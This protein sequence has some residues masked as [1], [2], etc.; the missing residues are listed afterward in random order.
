[1]LFIR[2]LLVFVVLGMEL[3]EAASPTHGSKLD[4]RGYEVL[5]EASSELNLSR[6][7]L[8]VG[9]C[10]ANTPCVNGAC[11]GSDNLCGYSPKQCGTG[12]R[13][14][15]DAK[16]ECGPYAPSS[17]QACPL[18]VCC[19][20]FGFCGSTSE[21]C[22]W[23]NKE[24][25]NYPSCNTKYGGCGDV[26]RPSCGGGSSVSKRTI[27]YYE[28]WANSRKNG[29]V[30]PEDLN[31][32]GF[33]H[34]NF[35]FSFFDASS[36][37][38][39][40]MDA[41]AASLYS[42]F[43][44]LKEKKNG[45]QAWISV[46]GWSFTDPGP[47]QKAFSN[48]VSSQSNR[49]KFI[50][51]LRQFMDTYGFDGVDLDWEYPGADDRGGVSAD[52]ANYVALTKEMRASFGTKYGISMTLPT[53]YWYLQ[54]FDLPGIQSSLDWFNLM[55]YDL[56]GTWDKA[57]KFVGPYLAPHTNNTEI[58]LGLDLLWRA[59]VNAEKVV[60]GLGLYGRSFTLADPSCNVPNGVCQFADAAKP[61]P[62]SDAAGI[63]IDTEINDII[64]K[65]NLKPTWDKEA[66]VKWITW[67]SNQWV[68]YDDSDTFQQKRDFANKRCLGGLMVWA[69]DQVDQAASNG[70]GLDGDVTSDQQDDAQ[71]LSDD[72]AA[73]MTCKATDCG[74]SC[75][76]G[77]N[78]VTETN[79][80]PG[81]LSTKDRC[82]KGQYRSICCSSGTTLGTCQWRGFRGHGLSCIGGCADG[83]TEVATNTNSHEG[84]NDLT[85]NGGQQS[86]CCKGFKPAV[87]KSELEKFAKDAAKAAAEAA[88]EQA[89]LDIA[90]KAFCRVAVPAL[91][92]P[93]ELLED[94]IP[95]VGEIL[96]IA[97]IAATPALIQL[98][99]KGIEK[100]GKAEFKVF[101][102][103]H[104]LSFDKP[105][106]KPSE[107]RPPTSSHD[108]PKTKTDDS[109]PNNRKRNDCDRPERGDVTTYD[110]GT[111]TLYTTLT[112]VCDGERWPQA[113][114]HYSSAIRNHVGAGFN[115]VTCSENAR[116]REF[117][118][119]GP[120]TN[121]WAVEKNNEWKKWMARIPTGFL[122]GQ[123][124][125]RDEWPPAHFWQ[126]DVG[127][128][129]RYNHR[130]D[131]AG[132]GSSL[133]SQF[134]PEHAAYRCVPGSGNVEN[135]RRGR[136]TTHCKKELT[137][138]GKSA[139][140][141]VAL[142][143]K[144]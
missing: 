117:M 2:S 116:P 75:P 118:G 103:K 37:E 92:A 36:F 72:Q 81:Q 80:Q 113:C 127:Q 32:D 61:G 53:S 71:S 39:T 33:T 136:P 105:T 108:S 13:Y 132:A 68:S 60:L 16:A 112:R 134:C 140:L 63:L 18:A 24:D 100:E 137:I 135:P 93:L 5:S 40:S 95:I 47:T 125:Q 9:T 94:L 8:P 35:A 31:L 101:G 106:K 26:K 111:T 49:A 3:C 77:S 25:S 57:S 67:D 10:D 70:L 86:Y 87:S 73:K 139:T 124:C 1:M 30:T 89:A 128:I 102:K 85:C 142:K 45:L 91:L 82:K 19:S 83:E 138:R 130:E 21:F 120:A 114:M 78:R 58:D 88:A 123:G 48:M 97:E 22:T 110:K 20:E 4:A 41:N 99:V 44:A 66:G 115:P 52:T 51:N 46:G 64:K 14:N 126:G 76:A 122:P 43:A 98:C 104:T 144:H 74:Q 131:N 62:I 69:M 141:N 107:T 12:C 38:I 6:R 34:I 50:G 7:D 23:T 65:N 90:A 133:W 129:I 55:A 59:G 17:S 143:P 56:H 84:K 54:H 11:C 119:P 27:G 15:C 121:Q 96:D 79:G 28:T 42:R 109:C 29:P